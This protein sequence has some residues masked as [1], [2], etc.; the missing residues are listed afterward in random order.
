MA[1]LIPD[2]FAKCVN[3]VGFF[4]SLGNPESRIESFGRI[5]AGRDNGLGHDNHAWS[6]N[7]ALIDG[8]FEPDIGIAGAFGPQVAN[9]GKSGH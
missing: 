9:R 8:L 1:D 6:R 2:H 5:A 3:S 4:R 7:D